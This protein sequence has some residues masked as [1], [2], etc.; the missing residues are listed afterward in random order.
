[1]TTET[2]NNP[3]ENGNV[4]EVFDESHPLRENVQT[5]E[6]VKKRRSFKETCSF[7]LKNVTVEPTMFLFILAM[8][9][10]VIT[11][12]NLNLEK[13]CRINLNFTSEICDSLKSQTLGEQNI[14]ER[15]VQQLVAKAMTWRT[16]ITA[17]LPCMLALFVG[18]WSDK[19]GYR[20][21]FLII[22]LAGQMLSCLNG[23]IN[24]Y[25]FNQLRL[26]VFVFTDAVIDGL[27]GSW[28][29]CLL[30]MFAYIS[31][32]TTNENR[33]FRMGIINFSLTVGFPIGMGL[34]GVLLKKIGYYGCYG[35]SG[36]LHF[37]N[38]LYNVF[39][40]KDPPRSPEQKLHDKKGKYHLARLFFN[41]TNVKD[42][43]QVV[44]KNGPNNRRLRICIMLLV[45]SILFGPMHGELAIMYIST[46]YRFNWDEVMFSIFQA[47]NF[48]TH[49]VG[50]LFSITV[51]S[52]YLGW[53][54]S[55]LGIISTTS[56][57]AASFFYCF[58]KN[59]RIFFIAPIVDILNGTSLLA[60]RSILSKMVLPE[61]FGKVN[62]I[63]ALTENLMP[64]VY[65]PLYTA[66]YIATM[67]VLPGAVFLMG[68]SMTVPALIVF[69]GLLWEYKRNERLPNKQADVELSPK[70]K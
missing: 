37:L 30:T 6:E 52:K 40:L 24:T 43:I 38:I 56:K 46:R 1:M 26:E 2:N 47:Y 9:T 66:V 4:S 57:I 64:L 35:I 23:I 34:S 3:V 36:S 41:L 28:C 65:V 54:D 67:E 10:T 32:I 51:F 5:Q 22:P 15:D 68:S 25:F 11:G 7:V 21:I 13:A 70:E 48:V 16:Y 14:Y 62:S 18:S 44:F 31:A 45:V 49:T 8:L 27:S 59:Q 53:H 55:I 29:V 58:A 17:S 69:I 42:T 63:F 60:M 12:Q 61:E 39:I 20:K 50:T 19:T 33:T